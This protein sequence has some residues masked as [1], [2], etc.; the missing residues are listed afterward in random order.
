MEGE[1]GGV[2]DFGSTAEGAEGVKCMDGLSCGILAAM[3]VAKE[4]GEK[5]VMGVTN[6]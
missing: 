5:A 2:W 3:E 1:C 6:N 4:V